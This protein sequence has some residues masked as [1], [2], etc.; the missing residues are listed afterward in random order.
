VT[1]YFYDFEFIEGAHS[2][3]PI[4]IGVAADDGREFY[5]VFADAPWER[6]NKHP[7]LL[8]HVLPQLHRTDDNSKSSKIIACEVKSFLMLGRTP[9]ELWAW[10]ASHDHTCLT[11]LLGGIAG[12][13]SLIPM[14]TNDLRQWQHQLGVAEMPVQDRFVHNAL[15]DAL[16][17]LTMWEFLDRQES[18]PRAL[19]RSTLRTLRQRMSSLIVEPYYAG[20][21]RGWCDGVREVI[22]VID[23]EI[24][25]TDKIEARTVH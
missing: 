14:W 12:Y 10:Y 18:R 16:H 3:H 17:N 8:E 21:K 25:I 9:P 11:Q 24:Q 23:N 19:H 1:R 2:L 22:R 13:P 4:S 15:G 7:W 20:R 6:V 5:R